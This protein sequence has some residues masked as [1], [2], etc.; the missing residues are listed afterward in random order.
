MTYSKRIA[1]CLLACICYLSA[2]AQ[3]EQYQTQLNMIKQAFDNKDIALLDGMIADSCTILGKSSNLLLPSLK[4]IYATL[5][6]NTID[7]MTLVSSEPTAN[8]GIRLYL[9]NKLFS[10]WRKR[11]LFRFR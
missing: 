3:Q 1:I 10:S 8:G 7:S 4:A 6:N 9:Q 11:C 2:F 5:A